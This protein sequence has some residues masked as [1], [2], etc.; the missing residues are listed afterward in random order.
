MAI[1]SDSSIEP[2]PTDAPRV[3]DVV[4]DSIEEVMPEEL[5]V[6]LGLEQFDD[7]EVILHS[8]RDAR[9]RREPLASGLGEFV[10]LATPVVWLIL[11]HVAQRIAERGVDGAATRMGSLFRKVFR[12][13]SRTTL[14]VPPL[15]RE[16]MADVHRRILEEAVRNKISVQKASAI[17]DAVVA[18]LILDPPGSIWERPAELTDGGEETP[19][20]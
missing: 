3:R 8:L 20:R 2:T 10:V 9:R 11:D 12:R 16:Q 14:V 19:D 18:R 5:P 7:D 13:R 6:V 15:N 4:R 17:A 1:T